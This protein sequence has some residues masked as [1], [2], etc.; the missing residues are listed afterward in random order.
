MD[1]QRAVYVVEGRDHG[2][3]LAARL[4]DPGGQRLEHRVPWR[5]VSDA[6]F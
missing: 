1:V 6:F 4:L 5:N 3:D 2:E